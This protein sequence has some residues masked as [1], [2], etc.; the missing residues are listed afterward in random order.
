[1]NI[2]KFNEEIHSTLVK[3]RKFDKLYNSSVLIIGASGMIGSC[4]V[5]VFMQLNK[6]YD[7]DIKVYAMARNG[8]YLR[9]RFSNYI[10]NSNFK[11][12][13]HDICNEIDMNLDV[14]YIIH[15]GSN[16]DPAM[17]SNNPVDTITS[18]FIGMN[19]LL[20]YYTSNNVKR[21]LY[22]SS[23]EM[24]GLLDEK[25]TS[26][27]EDYVGYLDYSSPRTSYPSGKR[28]TEV[29]CQSYISQYDADI[30]IARPCHIYGPTMKENDSRAICQ[31]IRSG[32]KG[33]DIVLKSDGL[34]ERSHCYVIDSATALLY[35][36]AFGENGEAYNISD[37]KSQCTIKELAEKIAE[38]SSVDIKFEIPTQNEKA[39]FSKVNKAVL[40]SEKLEMLEWSAVTN[41]EDG[42]EKTI[43]HL[44]F[45][46]NS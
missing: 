8:A 37:R 13:E 26:F 44:K 36:L 22:I 20:K 39:S 34:L 2:N 18:N 28:A 38:V 7:A 33:K 11:I 31:F 40:S 19:N 21:L 27:S 15:G 16:A 46:L 14:D 10:P 1:M 29:L 45:D 23:G 25:N 5:D 3:C 6:L 32:S 43:N 4:L 30:V 17:I 41:L 12:L 35:I 9:S 42:I 24:Y